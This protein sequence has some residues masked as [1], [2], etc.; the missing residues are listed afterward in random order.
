[1]FASPIEAEQ[2]LKQISYDQLQS[3]Q[4][5][6]ATSQFR[7][8]PASHPS[9]TCQR[10]HQDPGDMDIS[11]DSTSTEIPERRAS[12]TSKIDAIKSCQRA[13]A[14][15][16][17]NEQLDILSHLFSEVA[18]GTLNEPKVPTDF[19]RLAVDAMHNL[20][21]SG[22]SNTVY[23]LAKALGT[24][25]TDHS[26]T[27][28]PVKRM[29]MGLIEYAVTFFSATSVQQVHKCMYTSIHG[30]HYNHLF[31]SLGKLSPRL[32][33]VVANTLFSL[34]LQNDEDICWPH[35]EL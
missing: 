11:L 33:F 29:P 30:Q 3:S 12:S 15:F 22:W 8:F 21:T 20:R 4:R 18:Y 24:M 28:L 6:P 17:P 14:P 10:Q 31:L 27:L 35:V 13:L 7:V 9:G 2:H 5:N 16:Q 32:S 19:L 25:R 34:R 23:L 1:M 26:D